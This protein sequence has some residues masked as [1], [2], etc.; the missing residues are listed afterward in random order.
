MK[1]HEG[2]DAVAFLSGEIYGGEANVV[3][4]N[5]RSDYTYVHHVGTLVGTD[6]SEAVV[7]GCHWQLAASAPGNRPFSLVARRAHDG[8]Q[9]LQ[10]LDKAL[11]FPLRSAGAVG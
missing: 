10:P 4:P 2:R 5:C 7:A 3:C 9:G 1:I 6:R 11:F 8:C